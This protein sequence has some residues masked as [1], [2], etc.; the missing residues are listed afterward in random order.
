LNTYWQ[1]LQYLSQGFGGQFTPSQGSQ[2]SH[3]Q[4]VVV[5][6]M[7]AQAT[8]AIAMRFMFVSGD[9]TPVRGRSMRDVRSRDGCGCGRR[10]HPPVRSLLRFL[11]ES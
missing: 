3:E 7:R 10:I 6:R 2:Q 4:P 5:A 8:R 1:G 11:R 9:A